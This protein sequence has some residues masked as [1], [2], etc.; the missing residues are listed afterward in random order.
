LPYPQREE[1]DERIMGG[2]GGDGHARESQQH[3]VVQEGG[4]E[5]DLEKASTSSDKAV[6]GR[7]ITATAS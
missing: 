3:Q 2:V 1:K 6:S 7:F 5:A 4:P